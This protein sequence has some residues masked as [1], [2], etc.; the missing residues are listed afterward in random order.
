[1]KLLLLDQGLSAR[2][3]HNAATL[4][5]LVLQ[6]ASPCGIAL[7]CAT[8][9]SLDRTGLAGLP[10]EWR[11]VFRLHGY[12]R[13]LSDSD[14]HE[15][16]LQRLTDLCV[17]DLRQLDL[18]AYDLVLMP[19]AYPVHLAALAQHLKSIRAPRL[20][21]GLLMP[22]SFWA[23]DAR[24]AQWLDAVM[25]QSIDA[26]QMQP[27]VSFFSE[28]GEYRTGSTVLWLP[29]LLPPIADRTHDWIAAQL[30][31][32]L[33]EADEDAVERPLVFGF[34]GDPS[35]RKGF[36]LLA[37]CIQGGLPGGAHLS[38][39]L[40][41][42]HEALAGALNGTAPSVTA[43]TLGPGNAQ[44]LEAMQAVDVVLAFYDPAVYGM[45]MSGQKSA[46]PFLRS[47]STQLSRLGRERTRD[48]SRASTSLPCED[49]SPSSG[50]VA[51]QIGAWP[52]FRSYSQVCGISRSTS[53]NGRLSA[54][55]TKSS[56][57]TT[58]TR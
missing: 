36:E 11:P 27:D 44:Y 30:A 15:P 13:F 14:S 20:C 21:I 3:G 22:P 46:Q 41:T 49:R 34:F 10:C 35:P 48:H 47:V 25:Q 12:A 40:P 9:S 58:V 26:L 37:H 53:G 32:P 4:E 42:R 54:A 38:V 33:P 50:P 55:V 56:P 45:Q 29:T 8:A 39:A 17:E 23:C 24:A 1:M 16:L 5:E 2:T 19:T 7:T 18:A 28:S 6:A 43:R 57:G 51:R 31:L 52:M